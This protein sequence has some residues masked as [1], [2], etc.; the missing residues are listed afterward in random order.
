MAASA[1]APTGAVVVEVASAEASEGAS[2]EVSVEATE[3]DHP[4]R[5]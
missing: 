3:A 5:T 2:V 1:G 4:G